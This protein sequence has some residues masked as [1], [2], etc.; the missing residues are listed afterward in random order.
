[1]QKSTFSSNS[2]PTFGYDPKFYIGATENIEQRLAKHRNKNKGFTNQ[3]D[4]W[5]IVYS[6]E[7][8]T[9]TEALAYERLIKSWKS[10]KK[11]ISLIESK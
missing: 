1:M 5:Q 3:A 9:K 8:Q 10:K 4:D 7:F 2:S 11:I 6:K